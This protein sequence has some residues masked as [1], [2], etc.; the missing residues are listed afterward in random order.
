MIVI[1]VVFHRIFDYNKHNRFGNNKGT[2][3]FI[4]FEGQCMICVEQVIKC[5]QIEQ[6]FILDQA[7]VAM[8]M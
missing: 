4:V 2:I 3:D 1:R 5:L 8:A 6:K 7:K